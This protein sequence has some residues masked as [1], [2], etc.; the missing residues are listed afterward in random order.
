MILIGNND[1]KFYV[2]VDFKN[3][4]DKIFLNKLM[5]KFKKLLMKFFRKR[6]KFKEVE[7]ICERCIIKFLFFII[8]IF[9]VIYYFY[10]IVFVIYFIKLEFKDNLIEE[11]CVFYLMVFRFYFINNVMNV[12]FYGF[13]DFEFRNYCKDIYKKLYRKII[14]LNL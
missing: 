12:F 1:L 13:F 2:D 5:K 4:K 7:S 14:M 10:I 11:G 9:I 6:K 8:L 3:L